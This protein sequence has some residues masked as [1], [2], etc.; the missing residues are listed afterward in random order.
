M[1]LR[2]TLTIEVDYD[3][4]E[5]VNDLPGYEDMSVEDAIEHER[6]AF[7]MDPYTYM[8]LADA[9]MENVRVEA[10]VVEEEAQPKIVSTICNCDQ[11]Q[12]LRQGKK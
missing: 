7:L 12:H 4:F 11:C 9:D 3:G 6:A 8:D 1:K 5:R 2:Y 10:G